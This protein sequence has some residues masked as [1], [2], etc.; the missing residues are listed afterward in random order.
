MVGPRALQ[1]S[2][3]LHPFTNLMK[4]GGL[5]IGL[6]GTKRVRPLAT[7]TR[8]SARSES[9]TVL[10]SR[11]SSTTLISWIK[12]SIRL[13]RQFFLRRV[14]NPISKTRSTSSPPSSN[15]QRAAEVADS[16]RVPRSQTAFR[17]MI[18]WPPPPSRQR[19]STRQQ[20]F[21]ISILMILANSRS[22]KVRLSRIIIKWRM[23]SIYIILNRSSMRKT[24]EFAS[25]NGRTCQLATLATLTKNSKSRA[26]T[27]LILAKV[28]RIIVRIYKTTTTTKVWKRYSMAL[29]ASMIGRSLRP[30]IRSQTFTTNTSKP[31]LKSC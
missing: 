23:R 27:R 16:P 31:T 2:R 22:G 19:T 30:R 1:I 11:R 4:V 18:E 13:I 26:A 29:R 24:S 10:L 9:W 21:W 17:V 15:R 20:T 3:I 28:R 14:P 6:R 25:Q 7:W 5:G 12:F 8:A